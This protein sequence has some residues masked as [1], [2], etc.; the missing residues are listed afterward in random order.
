MALFEVG[1]ALLDWRQVGSLIDKLPSP[2]LPPWD[3][4]VRLWANI[5]CTF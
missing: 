4:R 3:R 2:C 1:W 5:L